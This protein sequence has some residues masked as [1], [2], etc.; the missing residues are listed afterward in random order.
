MNQNKCIDSIVTKSNTKFQIA[1]WL[2]ECKFS[3]CM[4]EYA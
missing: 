4:Q 2:S 1:E 3:N